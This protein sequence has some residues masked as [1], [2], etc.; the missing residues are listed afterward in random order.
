MCDPQISPLHGFDL[1][2]LFTWLLRSLNSHGNAHHVAVVIRTYCFIPVCS[3]NRNSRSTKVISF[4][5]RPSFQVLSFLS[6]RTRIT[7]ITASR[8][9]SPALDS[10]S[11]FSSCIAFCTTLGSYKTSEKNTHI[12]A[13]S[14]A[15]RLRIQRE[16][17]YTRGYHS[18]HI[19][20]TTRDDVESALW[21][22]V[23]VYIGTCLDYQETQV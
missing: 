6:C 7:R 23:A 21:R 15:L 13:Q 8:S 16:H 1:I 20:N 9:H 22:M 10:S 12:H 18:F 4:P 14:I 3:W 19:P 2:L 5:V 11:F 17:T